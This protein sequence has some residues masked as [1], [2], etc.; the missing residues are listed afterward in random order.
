MKFGMIN[1]EDVDLFYAT[2][3]VDDAFDFITREL[4]AYAVDNPGVGL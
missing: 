2:N 1:R 3:S 4:E